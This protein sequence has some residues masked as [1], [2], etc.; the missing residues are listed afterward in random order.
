MQRQQMGSEG[1]YQGNLGGPIMQDLR[2]I[3]LEATA[4]IQALIREV[5]EEL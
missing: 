3:M 5:L 4:E 1:I 2:D